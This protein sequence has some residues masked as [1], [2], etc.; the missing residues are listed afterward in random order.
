MSAGTV[1]PGLPSLEGPGRAPLRGRSFRFSPAQPEFI[2][3]FLVLLNA[4]A[5]YGQAAWFRANITNHNGAEDWVI[6]VGVALVIEMIGVYL[7]GMAHAALMADQ[8]AGLLRFGS[9]AIGLLVG[10][11]NYWH[12]AGQDFSPNPSA[13]TFGALSTIS[14]WLWAIYSR[15]VNRAQLATLGLVDKRGVKL[16]INRKFWHP[17]KSI[18]VMSY[19]S[20]EGITNPDEAVRGWELR[21]EL[22]DSATAPVSPSPAGRTP[23]EWV[24][25]AD[26]VKA[27]HPEWTAVQVAE[28]VGCSD[29]HIRNCRK[30]VPGRHAAVRS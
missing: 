20:W 2:A 16:S 27:E 25:L 22:D 5:I 23:A 15:Y 6:P 30:Q 12:F 13:I 7:S 17:V 18:K 11:L 21:K 3:A 8:S 24:E 1:S 9:Y 19:A 28:A 4:V 29:R 10:F 26:A 14:P